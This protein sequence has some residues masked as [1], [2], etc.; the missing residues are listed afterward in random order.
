VAAAPPA[1]SYPSFSDREMARRQA[2]LAAAMARAG[3]DQ[4]V[5]YGSE[6]SGGAVTWFTQWPV[7]REAVVVWRPGERPVLLVQF[8]NHVPNARRMAQD[9][10]VDWAG[11][12][13]AEAVAQRLRARGAPGRVGLVGA[14]PARLHARLAAAGAELVFLDEAYTSLRLVKSGEEIAWLRTGAELTDL[15]V[16]ALVAGARPGLSEAE[17]VALLAGAYLGRGGT[18]HIHYLGVTG[19]AAPDGCVPAQWPSARRLLPGDALTCEISA[20][21]WGYPGQ[22]LRTFAVAAPPTALYQELHRVASAAFDAL[23]AQLRPGATAIDLARAASVVEAAGFTTCDDL[24]HGFGGG[25]LPPIVP[26]GGRPPSPGPPLSLVPGMALV[27][28]PNVVTQ[29]GRAGVQVGELFV[30]TERGAESL[31]RF[32]WG[33]SEIG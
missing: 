4:V 24:V 29:D 11:P 1:A 18:T 7:T 5:L 14:V 13:T 25:Y 23:V 8:A 2:A 15:A 31:H 12:V 9:A 26:G 27:V 10:V 3:V 16:Q 17:L 33:L 21:W 19:M 28:Q 30:I 22:L 6:R 20:S 32:P